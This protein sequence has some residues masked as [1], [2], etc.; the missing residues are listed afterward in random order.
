VKKTLIERA[1]ESV[2]EQISWI[3]GWNDTDAMTDRKLLLLIVKQLDNLEQRIE[4]IESL[5]DGIDDECMNAN[6]SLDNLKYFVE[7]KLELK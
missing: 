1:L 6:R 5:V 3:N 2:A 7:N 4:N